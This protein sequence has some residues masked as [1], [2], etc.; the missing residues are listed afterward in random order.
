MGFNLSSLL[1]RRKE[2]QER[3]KAL[4][5]RI[6]P[7]QDL[8]DK[9]PVLHYGGI[10]RLN[11]Q[12][13]QFEVGGTVTNSM[14]WDYGEFMALPKVEVFADMHCVT[15]WSKLDNTWYG[16]PFVEI[17]KLVE[18]LANSKHVTVS[19]YGD[20]TTNVPLE[21]LMDDDVLFAFKHNR[22]DLTPE[23]GWPLRLVVPKRYAWK[24]AKWVRGLTFM[25]GDRRGFWEN[26]GYNNN[27]DP[28][29]EER[30][31]YQEV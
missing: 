29:K 19:S 26:L 18:P 22:E 7:G 14:V 12:T 15:G 25:P 1:A 10:P 3:I 27:G 17:V 30:Y 4:Q 11:L 9:W 23:H 21:V 13:W 28:W 6:P 8:T 5:H 24:S 31:S 20:Y 16:V 2:R